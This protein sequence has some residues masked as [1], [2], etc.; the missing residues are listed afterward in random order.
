M[1]VDHEFHH[2]KDRARRAPHEIDARKEKREK[3]AAD[4]KRAAEAVRAAANAE[5]TAALEAE[6]AAAEPTAMVRFEGNSGKLN[7]PTTILT[8]TQ[9]GTSSVFH[10]T[11]IAKTGVSMADSSSL[12]AASAR[13]IVGN[14]SVG[15][16]NGG[17]SSS[18][19]AEQSGGSPTL[20]SSITTAS[21]DIPANVTASG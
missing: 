13:G 19:S 18:I 14:L 8:T 6:K 11:D 17:G 7:T 3:K 15:G 4:K 10:G 20:V 9:A 16:S 5:K 1:Q 2:L 21:E 12:S